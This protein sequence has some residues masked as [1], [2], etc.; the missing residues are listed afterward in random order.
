M[1]LTLIRGGGKWPAG[2]LNTYFSAT[3][4]LIDLKPSCIFKFVLCL[5]V[6][7]KKNDQFGPCRDPG[8][9]FIGKGPPKSASQGQF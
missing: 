8:G 2:N 5:E 9:F 1:V 7:Q 6:Y 3:E 4:C